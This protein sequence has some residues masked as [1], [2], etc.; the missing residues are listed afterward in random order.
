[1]TLTFMNHGF[2]YDVLARSFK[3]K[4]TTFERLI[5]KCATIISSFV[6]DFFVTEV[7]NLNRMSHLLKEYQLFHPFPYASYSSYATDV[8]F[9]NFFCRS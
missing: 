9:Q 7:G 3:L 1:M 6:Y 8:T 4:G 2:Q 5:T